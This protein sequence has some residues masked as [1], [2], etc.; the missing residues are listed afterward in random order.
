MI[1]GPIICRRRMLQLS[2]LGVWACFIKTEKNNQPVQQSKFNPEGEIEKRV[3][4]SSGAKIPVIGLGTWQTFDVDNSEEERSALREVLKTLVA[5]GASVIDSSPMYGASETVVG[6]LSAELKIRDKLFLATKVWTSGRETGINQMNESFSKM[7]TK[8]MDLMQV[9]NLVDVHTHIKTLRSWK[10]QGK[11]KYFGITH[12]TSSAY[13]DLIRLIKNEKPDFVQFNYNISVREAENE[14][15][16]LAED[17]GVAIIINRPFE[18]GALFTSVRGKNLP[19]WVKEYDINSWG[20]Y[21]LKFIISNPA[22]TCVIP[23]T[24]KVKHLEDNLGAGFGKLPD[25][26]GRKKLIEYFKNL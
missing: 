11:I 10:E 22:V 15:L 16:P 12:Y 23:G 19:E 25:Q 3:I 1:K 26:A 8:T 6:D 9:H 7:K 14:L 4:K 24:S 20:Q 5:K 2:S 13:P 21:F 17:K 18:E